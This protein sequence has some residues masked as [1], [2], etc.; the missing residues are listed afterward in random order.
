MSGA[1]DVKLEGCVESVRMRL[2]DLANGTHPTSDPVKQILADKIAERLSRLYF[3][4]GDN[5]TENIACF[6]K[7]MLLLEKANIKISG[8]FRSKGRIAGLVEDVKS[9]LPTALSDALSSAEVDDDSVSVLVKSLNKIFVV[10][11]DRDHKS[12][13]GKDHERKVPDLEAKHGQLDEA[14]ETYLDDL[15]PETK[16]SAKRGASFGGAGAVAPRAT[17]DAARENLY[18]PR[19]RPFNHAVR[20]GGLLAQ[21]KKGRGGVSPH[22]R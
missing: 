14:I 3:K 16:S 5:L 1:G 6:A 15:A 9:K 20:E 10:E 18:N 11:Y 2:N 7:L 21:A 4:D 12:G 22:S 13:N 8:R 17:G 19:L